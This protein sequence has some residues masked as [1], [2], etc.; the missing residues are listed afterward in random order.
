MIQIFHGADEETH[1]AFQAWRR[2][3]PDGFHMTESARGA[4]TVHY[5]QDKRDN[6]SGR[7]C[8]HQ[9]GSDNRF[10]EDKDGCYT[11]ERKVCSEAYAELIVWAKTNSFVTRNCKHC[12]TRRFPFPDSDILPCVP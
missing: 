3:N 7:G 9:G 11:S 5:A 4:F 6:G 8:A 10:R 2:G 12:D 1:E